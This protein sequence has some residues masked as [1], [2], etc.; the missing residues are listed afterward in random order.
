M[1]SCRQDCLTACK[2]KTKSGITLQCN[3][4]V[5]RLMTGVTTGWVISAVLKQGRSRR[6]SK[7]HAFTLTRHFGWLVVRSST[8]VRL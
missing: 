6:G 3:M 2:R 4:A 7:S 1:A 8:H 5:L